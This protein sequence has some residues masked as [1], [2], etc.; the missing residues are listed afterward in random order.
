MSIGSVGWHVNKILTEISMK[1]V[2]NYKIQVEG[3]VLT[4]STSLF[5]TQHGYMLENMFAVAKCIG[6][7]YNTG[8]QSS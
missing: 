7:K 2:K 1:G 8:A 4:N 5:A 6:K 3:I